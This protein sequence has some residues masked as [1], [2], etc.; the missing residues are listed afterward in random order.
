M[1]PVRSAISRSVCAFGGSIA[2]CVRFPLLLLR[3]CGNRYRSI[4][5]SAQIAGNFVLVHRPHHKFVQHV[6]A[7]GVELYRLALVLVFFL[8]PK[9]TPLNSSHANISYAVFC[10][11]KKKP[12]LVR[13]KTPTRTPGDSPPRPPGR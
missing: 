7:S 11:K 13:S 6:I 8:D 2:D 4:L 3:R 9:S 5:R 10:L 1:I 12:S